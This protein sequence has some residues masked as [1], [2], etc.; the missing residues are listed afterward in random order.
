MP[1]HFDNLNE[2]VIPM[3]KFG[4]AWRFTDE[5]YTL[6]PDDHLAQLKPL[7]KAASRF[8]WDFIVQIQLHADVPFK[9]SFF[10]VIDRTKIDALDW[11][12]T[13][14][15]LYRRGLLFDNQVYLS[16]QPDEAMITPWKLF[17]KYFDSFYYFDDLTVIDRSLAWALLCYHESELYFGT[18][19]PYQAS[20]LTDEEIFYEIHI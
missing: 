7:S 12:K 20:P 4:L 11:A 13:K 9:K 3:E 14:K 2:Q 10:K 6:L 15:W 19:K 5:K 8:L 17:V 1:I 18:N 16:W